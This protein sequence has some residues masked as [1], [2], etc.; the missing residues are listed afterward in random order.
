MY[1]PQILQS[2]VPNQSSNLLTFPSFT[3]LFIPNHLLPETVGRRATWC[4]LCPSIHFLS[5]PHLLLSLLGFPCKNIYLSGLLSCFSWEAKP[6]SAREA[7]T[8]WVL[9]VFPH[10]RTMG[11]KLRTVSFLPSTAL[12]VSEGRCSL[13][14]SGCCQEKWQGT[15]NVSGE[16]CRRQSPA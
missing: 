10:S 14:L 15:S 7:N 4:P 9:T 13:P 1:Q 12:V 5:S 11:T 3:A 8:S 16:L 6:Q 2:L